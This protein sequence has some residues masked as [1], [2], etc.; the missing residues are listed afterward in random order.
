MR[1]PDD[2][3][4]TTRLLRDEQVLV[5]IIAA[6]EEPE[7]IDITVECSTVDISADGLR[8]L[9]ECAVPKG[10]KLAMEVEMVGE[11]E[12]YYLGGE[13]MWSHPTEADGL[14]IIGIRLVAGAG[15][16]LERW[17]SHFL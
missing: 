15:F 12:R 6:P 17:H 10:A 3:R 5:K 11:N 7:L 4:N 13:V 9:L 2:R 14:F 1:N 8:L 16:E